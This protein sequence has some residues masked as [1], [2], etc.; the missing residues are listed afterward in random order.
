LYMLFSNLLQIGQTVV[1]KNYVI[2]HDKIR[3]ELEA[4]K[5]KPKK[6][7]KFREMMENA[8]RM[9]QEQTKKK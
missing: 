8:Q 9:Q 6:T 4:N 5:K 7:S 2:N 1:T 3:L